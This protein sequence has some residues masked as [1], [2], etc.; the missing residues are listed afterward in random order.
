MMI[1]NKDLIS[2]IIPI[3]KA[4]KYLHPCV[5]SVL[6]QSYTEFE[7]LLVDDG[8]PDE[9]G[10]ICDDYAASDSR[11]VVIHKDN[12]GVSSARNLGLDRAKGK[13]IV[14][15]DSDDLIV[16]TFLE[17]CMSAIKS[18]GGDL[19]LCGCQTLEDNH[20]KTLFSF[21][22]TTMPI[23]DFIE[24]SYLHLAC[25]AYL[26]DKSIIDKYNIRFNESLPM[27]E[28]RVFVAQ[29][30][31]RCKKIS[32]IDTLAYIYRITNVSACGSVMTLKKANSQVDA[33]SFLLLDYDDRS[34]LCKTIYPIIIKICLI[35]YIHS[36]RILNDEKNYRNAMDK[37]K[38][39]H[40]E[41]N[42]I[43]LRIPYSLFISASRLNIAMVANM[44][45]MY[46]KMKA[47]VKRVLK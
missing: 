17:D 35:E 33:A 26:L 32:T 37:L 8:S 30:L 34:A 14:F 38:S 23:K 5:E 29:Y 10:R 43:N 27:S 4:E 7:L 42:K 13:W 11:V 39:I 40:S 9:S 3:Y 44:T 12:G 18:S 46:Y 45:N 24:H 22:N 20:I 6:A 19:C 25:W 41:C 31:I 2:I 21:T 16:S 47:L 28:D 1:E 15:I 36:I